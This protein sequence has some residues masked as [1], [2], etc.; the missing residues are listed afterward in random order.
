ME[1]KYVEVDLTDTDHDHQ[2]CE[3]Q[4]SG[5]N[6]ASLFK[7]GSIVLSLKNN[8]RWKPPKKSL[9]PAGWVPSSS[10]LSVLPVEGYVDS[11]QFGCYKLL[12]SFMNFCFDLIGRPGTF[13]RLDLQSNSIQIW[14]CQVK[15]TNYTASNKEMNTGQLKKV[16]LPD[17]STLDV[18]INPRDI[19]SLNIK[20]SFFHFRFGI[21]K[22]VN[23]GNARI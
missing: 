13:K 14:N 21:F 16:S 19:L 2:C 18:Q 7:P 22:V 9:K 1:N 17:V 5:D 23:S 15:K 11:S 4:E 20:I 10:S 12:R 6:L 8:F 3:S